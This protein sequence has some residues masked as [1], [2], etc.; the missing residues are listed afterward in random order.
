MGLLHAL[1]NVSK[2]IS[3]LE[4][5]LPILN[6]PVRRDVRAGEPSCQIHRGMQRY[7]SV[8]KIGTASPQT[9]N[10]KD[11]TPVERANLLETTPLFA[12]IHAEAASSGQTSVPTDLDTD[13]HF[14]C[15]VKA[16]E[17]G[18]RATETPANKMRLIELDG[19]RIGPIDRGECK[20]LL[21]V[22]YISVEVETTLKLKK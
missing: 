3:T 6:V 11:K 21:A 8:F 10:L 15:F 13:L 5:S 22:S 20:D 1:A 17:A 9:P 4:L 18:A 7:E 2:N 12:D 19:G 16:P 14:T